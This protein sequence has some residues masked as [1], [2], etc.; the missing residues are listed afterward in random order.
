MRVSDDVFDDSDDA[1][2]DGGFDPDDVE[3]PD[4]DETCPICGDHA[5]VTAVVP[6]RDGPTPGIQCNNCRSAWSSDDDSTGGIHVET[7]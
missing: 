3:T 1:R 2:T 7:R 6:S 5:L 4:V